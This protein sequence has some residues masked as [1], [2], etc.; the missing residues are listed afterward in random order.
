MG[1]Q[2]EEE[3]DG[4]DAVAKTTVPSTQLV[5]KKATLRVSRGLSWVQSGDLLWGSD[6]PVRE[7]L[8]TYRRR[9]KPR[10]ITFFK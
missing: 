3:G 2:E 6:S 5:E 4:D 9:T 10:R 1:Q 7:E 8:S